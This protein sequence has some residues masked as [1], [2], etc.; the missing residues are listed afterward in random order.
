MCVYQLI[1]VDLLLVSLPSILVN[2]SAQ[3]IVVNSP[4]HLKGIHCHGTVTNVVFK[5]CGCGSEYFQP[6]S[7][8][9]KISFLVFLDHRST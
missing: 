3:W 8:F 1:E 2:A 4:L 9:M 5:M 6:I 7:L